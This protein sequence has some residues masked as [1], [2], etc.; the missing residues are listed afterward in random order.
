MFTPISGV[1]DNLFLGNNTLSTLDESTFN[2]L[3]D[4]D[5]LYLNDN[6]LTT[7][8]TDLFD[9]LSI[10][11][12]SKLSL[13]RNNITTLH[14]DIFDGLDGLD[15]LFL[16]GNS[17]TTLP[18]DVF[19]NLVDLDIL[20]LDENS[21]ASLP[22]DVFDGLSDVH[23]LRLSDN[24]LTTL[25]TNVFDPLDKLEQL[26]LDDNMISALDATV[27]DGVQTGDTTDLGTLQ[28]LYL[29]DNGLT[30]LPTTVFDP[31]DDSL[32]ELHLQDN[33]I[34]SLHA[35]I[36][37]GLGGLTDLRLSNNAVS[38]L[39]A[40]VFTDLDASLTLLFLQDI[41]GSTDL[42]TLPANIFDGLTGLQALDL[43]CNALTALD[44]TATSPFNP[45]ASTL[46]YLDIR[47]N[48]FT[49]APTDANL[50]AKLTNASL[51]FDRDGTTPCKSARETGLSG[52]TVSPGTLTPS[53]TAP[54]ARVY[55]VD[56]ADTVS[57]VTVT[58]TAEDPNARVQPSS[59]TLDTNSGTP[60]IEAG[61]VYGLN[62]IQ[63]EV[64]PRDK[65]GTVT[66]Q[67]DVTRAYPDSPVALLR[68][69]TL[70]GVTLDTEFNGNTK[71]YTALALPTLTTTTVDPTPLDP[72][73]TTVIKINDAVDTD[74][75][76]QPCA[77]V[78]HRHGGSHRGRWDQHGDLHHHRQ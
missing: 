77:D 27:F 75:D 32:T 23:D 33:S 63:V 16:N 28:L 65:G 24:A 69:L 6:A 55:Y 1:L 50:R 57:S 74:G 39:D 58:A 21:I 48:S 38:T 20:Q 56:V 8:P 47:S 37:D 11:E 71:T 35:D 43:S 31:L 42:T 46:T 41:G 59:T 62:V 67:I 2:G 52:L 29:N 36:F 30:A 25:P 34:A 53:F 13:A 15:W 14:V 5:Q 12:M 4:L 10:S 70:S 45:F 68:E 7:L 22:G 73:A 40:G 78:R 44:L 76:G 19:D 72:D 26:W 17:L 54:G 51:E 49:T 66:T 9:G 61:L 18:A 64:R 60:A 3:S